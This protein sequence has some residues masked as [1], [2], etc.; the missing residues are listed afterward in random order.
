MLRD[1]DSLYE[2]NRSKTLLK[3]KS[4]MDSEA[5]ILSYVEDTHMKKNNVLGGFIVRNEEGLEFEVRLGLKIGVKKN[6]PEIG[7]KITYKYCG[8]NE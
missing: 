2:G 3:V 6:R 8:I 5:T 4:S 7:S 1:P